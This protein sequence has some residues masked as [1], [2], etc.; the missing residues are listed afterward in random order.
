[1]YLHEF[2]EYTRLAITIYST[3]KEISLAVY[4]GITFLVNN[5][6]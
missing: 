1:M 3:E 2:T 6:Q 4:G 5:E